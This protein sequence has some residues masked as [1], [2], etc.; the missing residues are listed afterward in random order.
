MLP[1]RGRKPVGVQAAYVI[2]LFDGVCGLCNWSI[3]FLLRHDRRGALRFAPLQSQGGQAL[4]REHGLNPAEFSSVVVIDGLQVY[5]RSDAALHA[6]SR[7]GAFW[8]ALAVLARVLPRSGRDA[9][10]D[11]V[12]KNRYRWFGQ[13][14]ICRIPAPDE[15][16]RFLPD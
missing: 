5:R 16:Q 4:L 8:R 11:W 7:L 15:R 9:I 1:D 13:R 12:A 2:V 10:Y 3:D 14:S 6:L